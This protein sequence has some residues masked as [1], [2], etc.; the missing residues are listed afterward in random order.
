MINL[1]LSSCFLDNLQDH[2]FVNNTTKPL[3]KI[4]RA[5]DQ[6]KEKENNNI[7]FLLILLDSFDNL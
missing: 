4:N 3:P 7:S 6:K 1:N 2:S 5:T